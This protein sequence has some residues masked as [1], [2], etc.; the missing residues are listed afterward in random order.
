MGPGAGKPSGKLPMPPPCSA[1][2]RTSEL[3]PQATDVACGGKTGNLIFRTVCNTPGYENNAIVLPTGREAGCFNI[4]AISGNP[5]FEIAAEGS[6]AAIY[7]YNSPADLPGLN[8]LVI[9]DTSPSASGK[10]QIRLLHP[11]SSPGSSVT[12]RFVDY[13]K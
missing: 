12:I 8:A 11:P 5:V 4:E 3:L 9:M 6:A 13:P 1:E 2:L 7:R 10:Y